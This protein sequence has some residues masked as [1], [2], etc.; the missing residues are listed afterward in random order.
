[1]PG[2]RSALVAGALLVA[3]VGVAVGFVAARVV[4]RPDA[5]S[6]DSVDVGFLRD[7]SDHHEQA[8]RMSLLVIPREGVAPAVRDLAVGIIASQR[9]DVGRMDAWLDDWGLARGAPDRGAMVWMG[10]PPVSPTAMP[11]MATQAELESLGSATGTD[12]EARFLDLMTA[13]HRAGVAMAEYAAAHAT[14]DKVVRLA[15]LIAAGQ[16]EEILELESLRRQ[17]DSFGTLDV[18]A[19]H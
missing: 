16:Q 8:V 18:G 4:D 13:H 9:H 2:R 7:M 11:G 17:L 6:E 5:P 12:A 14:R 15:E 19:P 3:V 10:H 1:V